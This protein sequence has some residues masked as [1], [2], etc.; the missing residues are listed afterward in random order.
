ML[1][2]LLEPLGLLEHEA[3]NCQATWTCASLMVKCTEAIKILIAA[4][5]HS[6]YQSRVVPSNFI[7]LAI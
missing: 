5:A 3:H 6:K 4:H 2:Y 1:E 7:T